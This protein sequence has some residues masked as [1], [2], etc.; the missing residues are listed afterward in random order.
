LDPIEISRGVTFSANASD[1]IITKHPT[2][3]SRAN[4]MGHL[5]V[6]IVSSFKMFLENPAMKR[7]EAIEVE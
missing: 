5:N 6:F 2:I 3:Q 4:A 7:V 1:G